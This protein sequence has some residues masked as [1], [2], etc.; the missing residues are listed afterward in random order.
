MNGAMSG[1]GH[2]SSDRSRAG[3][4][5][6]PGRGRARRPGGFAARPSSPPC[7][8][9]APGVRPRASRSVDHPVRVGGRSLDIEMLVLAGA[10]LRREQPAAMGVLEVAVWEPVALLGLLAG[11]VLDPE[12]PL[13][14][15][16][17]AVL[18]DEPVL[19]LRGWPVLAP[20]VTFVV[21][22]PPVLDQCL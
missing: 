11:L 22:E 7:S 20:G 12:V 5:R 21:D 10:A 19:S 8:W 16:A 17:P 15:L 18:V 13:P 3:T 1:R 6:G 14:V 4:R 9:L 2:V